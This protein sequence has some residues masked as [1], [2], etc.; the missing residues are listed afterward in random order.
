[1][2]FLNLLLCVSCLV[3]SCFATDRWQ[4]ECNHVRLPDGGFVVDPEY[5]IKARF[6]G[7]IKPR[8]LSSNLRPSERHPLYVGRCLGVGRGCCQESDPWWPEC[9]DSCD[10]AGH[11]VSMLPIPHHIRPVRLFVRPSEVF[12]KPH[13]Q[14]EFEKKL[15]KSQQK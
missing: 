4:T 13:I 15:K 11:E 5:P 9:G 14:R 2:W 1:M 10:N 6:S 12:L 8:D 3:L 7:Y